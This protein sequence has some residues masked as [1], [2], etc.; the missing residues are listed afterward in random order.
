MTKLCFT[1]ITPSVNDTVVDDP[2]LTVPLNIRNR[3][4]VLQTNQIVSLC[5]EVHGANDI[6]LNYVSD[7]CV[8]VNAH[9]FEL[10]SQPLI[11]FIDSIAVRAVDN[12]GH[13][14]NITVD[15][16]GCAAT[17]GNLPI[18][19]VFSLDGISVRRYTNR[20]RISVPNCAS[21]SL[22]MWVF[23]RNATMRDPIEVERFLTLEILRF[24][25]ARGFNLNEQSHGI[26]GESPVVS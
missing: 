17:V 11:H 12:K 22:V 25:I 8:S 1:G 16:E 5:Y 26:L 4:E 20:V 9:Y 3:D 24:V 7:D 23:C 21:Q 13:C 18:D 14:R 10:R 2:L 19:R 6:Y 15:L